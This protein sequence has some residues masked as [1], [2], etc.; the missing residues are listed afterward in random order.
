M[1]GQDSELA[2]GIYRN[3][4]AI[5]PWMYTIGQSGNRTHNFWRMKRNTMFR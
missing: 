3:G 2:L 4:L 1:M 5:S